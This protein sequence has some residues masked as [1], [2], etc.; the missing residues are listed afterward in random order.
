LATIKHVLTY[1]IIFRPIG[2]HALLLLLI[3]I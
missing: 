1:Y 2:A 3:D